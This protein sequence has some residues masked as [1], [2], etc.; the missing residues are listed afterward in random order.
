MTP[1][2]PHDTAIATTATGDSA[3]SLQ[4]ST[5]TVNPVDVYSAQTWVFPLTEMFVKSP[6]WQV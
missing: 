4:T 6:E 3:P 5:V 2:M 1:R